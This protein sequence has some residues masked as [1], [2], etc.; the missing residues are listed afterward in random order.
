MDKEKRAR[1]TIA[2]QRVAQ[3]WCLSQFADREMDAEFASAIVELVLSFSDERAKEAR[4]E[5]LEQAADHAEACIANGVVVLS[6]QEVGNA[7]R[8]LKGREGKA[9]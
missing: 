7:I 3:L 8:A 6:A 5:A 2:Y 4:S 1:E 9:E